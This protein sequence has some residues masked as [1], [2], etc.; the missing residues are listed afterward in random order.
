MNRRAFQSY[1]LNGTLVE[2]AKQD[3]LVMHC[4]PADRG[5]EITGEVMEGKHSVIFAQS[6]NR[7]PMHQAILEWVLAEAGPA[8]L[9]DRSAISSIQSKT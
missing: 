9:A 5:E 1:Q 4:L 2:K 3:L 8:S 7:F 6:A